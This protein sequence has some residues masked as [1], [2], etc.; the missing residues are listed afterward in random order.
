MGLRD[1]NEEMQRQ[2]KQAKEFEAQSEIIKG[3]GSVYYSVLLVY[4]E[5]NKVVTYRAAG[6]EGRA[7]AE[8]FRRHDHCWSKGIER[9]SEEHVSEES[10]A[11]F[12]EKLSLDYIRKHGEDYSLTYERTTSSG[13]TYIQARVSYVREKKRR[14]CRGCGN[15]KR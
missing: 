1:V 3:L 14:I 15:A 13:T 8:Y 9:H 10:R 6:E 2:L 12:K 7:I 11:E 5:T 4:P